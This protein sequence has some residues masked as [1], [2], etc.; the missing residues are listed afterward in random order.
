M[1]V[2]GD[3]EDHWASSTGEEFF[4]IFIIDIIMNERTFLSSRFLIDRRKSFPIGWIS[5]INKILVIIFCPI[6]QHHVRLIWVNLTNSYAHFNIRELIILLAKLYTRGSKGN[7][8]WLHNMIFLF[9]GESLDRVFMGGNSFSDPVGIGTNC[10][11]IIGFGKCKRDSAD[12][13]HILII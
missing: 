1:H 7:Q 6:L 3:C 2:F 13:F 5:R 4:N 11:E 12:N 10:D 9:Y 8:A